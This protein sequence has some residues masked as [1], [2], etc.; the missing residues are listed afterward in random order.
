MSTSR[1][2]TL[3]GKSK[4]KMLPLCG[5]NLSMRMNTLSLQ[6]LKNEGADSSRV[7]VSIDFKVFRCY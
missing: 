5:C 2:E 7:R 1:A 3:I 6:S 4:H